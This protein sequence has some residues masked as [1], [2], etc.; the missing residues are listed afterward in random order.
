MARILGLPDADHV[1]YSNAPLKLMLGQVRFPAILKIAAP[2]GLAGFQEE[3]RK[4]YSE[5]AEEQQLGLII[6]PEGMQPAGDASKNY[7]FATADGGWSIV[8]NQG[9]V[10]LEASIATKYSTYEEFH[11]R[12]QQAWDA[13]LRHLE[14]TRIAQQ[15]LRYVDFFDWD[16]VSLDNWGRYI[17]SQLL[18][19]LGVR[20]FVDHVE[21]TVTDA[22]LQLGDLGVM[23][24]KYGLSRGG[25]N[26]VPGFLLDT[27]VFSQTP[28]DDTSVD[29]VMER[30]KAFHEEIHVVFN[31]ATTPDARARF[32]SEPSG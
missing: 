9:F 31:W 23:S 32:S 24:L 11:D 30:F 28:Q 7:R 26:N 2:G 14:P 29:F 8:V 21:H 16:D 3:I 27:D 1:Q 12:F 22:R 13:V 19:V 4:D 18:G 10:T 25:P 20:E 6:S 5:Y 15:G 17:S